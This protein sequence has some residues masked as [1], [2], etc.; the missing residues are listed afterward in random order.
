V[1]AARSC[2]ILDLEPP[3]STQPVE[4]G[5]QCRDPC[6]TLDAGLGSELD[7]L[8]HAIK[9]C[10]TW[11]PVLRCSVRLSAADPTLFH[12]V[13]VGRDRGRPAHAPSGSG[14][15][16][17]GGALR[18]IDSTARPILADRGPRAVIVLQITRA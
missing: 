17:L 7:R 9:V 4:Q 18:A 10:E 11:I 5:R 13:M 8:Q 3:A 16:A 2:A 1:V 6:P 15:A 14:A 12:A